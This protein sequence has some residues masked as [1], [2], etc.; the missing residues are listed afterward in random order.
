MSNAIDN[1]VNALQALSLAMTS[2]DIKSA[3]AYPIENI[4]PLPMSVAYLAAGNL[5]K[6][7][8]GMLEIF[9]QIN[10]EFHFSR[11]N[12]KQAYQQIN[13]VAYEFSQRLSGDPTLSGAVDTL[14]SADAGVPFAVRPYNWGRPQGSNVDF[15]TQM[16]LFEIVVKIVESP[17]TP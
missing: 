7:N 15:F 17:I 4:D 13:A 5:M 2:V 11:L 6:I 10:V 9:P 16:L 8:Y 3:P 1:A 12:L 14:F